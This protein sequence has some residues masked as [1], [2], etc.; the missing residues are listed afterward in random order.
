M[1]VYETRLLDLERERES[2]VSKAEQRTQEATELRKQSRL[3]LQQLENKNKEI[4]LLRGQVQQLTQTHAAQELEIQTLQRSNDSLQADVSNLKLDLSVRGENEQ[5]SQINIQMLYR[6]I[7]ILK[8]R[9]LELEETN[10]GLMLDL[11]SKDDVLSRTT[12]EVKDRETRYRD[13]L[14]NYRKLS[15]DLASAR[16]KIGDLEESHADFHSTVI[17]LEDQNQKLKE[18][19]AAS[20]EISITL[21]QS[22]QE[23]HTYSQ[24]L[25]KEL[26]SARNLL[27]A[28]LDREDQLTKDLEAQ[29]L[30]TQTQTER[31]RQS[32]M[33][34]AKLFA[35]N[36][37][38]TERCEELSVQTDAA[39]VI[40][41]DERK[42]TVGMHSLLVSSRNETFT[43]NGRIERLESELLE[44]KAEIDELVK[45]ISK[46]DEKV[47][48]LM[49]QQTETS[50][51][52]TKLREE[53]LEGAT[54]RDS[55]LD[56][57]RT[58]QKQKKQLEGTIAHLRKALDESQKECGHLIEQVSETQQNEAFARAQLQTQYER[59]IASLESDL[60][61]IRFR[62][63]HL[64]Q[65]HTRLQQ[66]ASYKH[67][68]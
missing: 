32:E 64:S 6:E 51:Q 56:Q 19:L 9:N 24:T 39:D 34:I 21:S 15:N 42:K 11:E 57:S 41:T 31:L 4:L 53:M 14:E 29:E 55:V 65:D 43:L 26:T 49:K 8:H 47:L 13:V 46:K 37:L 58:F 61:T 48:E 22:L 5:E 63:S 20:E 3:L 66:L 44:K 67:P 59:R 35:Q 68:S 38:L 30:V 50:E 52:M 16:A 36:K 18:K 60:D 2:L 45:T 1:N 28:E 10:R 54:E 17:A 7:E 27:D 25:L 12:V 33:E 62:Y 23:F 40:A